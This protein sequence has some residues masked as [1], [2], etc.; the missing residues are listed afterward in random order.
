MAMRRPTNE[1]ALGKI[2][3]VGPVK[4]ERYGEKFLDV[5][6]SSDETEAA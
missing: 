1:N 6:R 4:L 5:L 2:R 3:G